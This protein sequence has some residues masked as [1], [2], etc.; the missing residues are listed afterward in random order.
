MN[1]VFDTKVQ[2]LKYQVLKEVIRRAY[3][4]DLTTAIYEIPRV[5]VPGPKSDM[6]CCIYKERAVLEE[7]V[8]L[9]MG[10]DK[11]NPNVIETLPDRMRRVPHR[12]VFRHPRLPRLHQPQMYGSLPGRRHQ[13]PQHACRNRSG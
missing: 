11:D 12:P 3:E 6:R 4:G 10:G 8:K 7:R 5:I 1:R 9:A 2:E 13:H